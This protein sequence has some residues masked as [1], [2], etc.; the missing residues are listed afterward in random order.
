MHFFIVVV[1]LYWFLFYLDFPVSLLDLILQITLF[2]VLA[3]TGKGL[4]CLLLSSL[5]CNLG[6]SSLFI[7]GRASFL[8]MNPFVELVQFERL[9]FASGNA[10]RSQFC[11]VFSI[12]ALNLHWWKHPNDLAYLI[13]LSLKSKGWLF[14][15][16][17]KGKAR[18]C[19]SRVPAAS[20][21]LLN[22]M[23]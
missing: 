12:S 3:S 18:S 16:K 23:P 14:W 5:K 17:K 22:L 20:L 9:N 21:C 15:K 6:F 8:S 10:S 13:S 1:L 7:K 2:Q 4:D 19:P 11:S